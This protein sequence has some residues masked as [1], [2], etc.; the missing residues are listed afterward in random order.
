[1]TN[2]K[3][4]SIYLNDHLAATIAGCDLTRRAASSNK[5]TALGDFLERLAA[6]AEEDKQTLE[7]LMEEIGVTKNLLKDAAAWLSEKVGRLKL[8]GQL[9]GYSDLSRL[10]ELDGISA[11]LEAKACLW[12]SLRGISDL[13]PR[14]A[15]ANL[16]ELIRRT[17]RQREEL[18]RFR[19]EIATRALAEDAEADEVEVAAHPT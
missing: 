8:N 5:G 9:V 3:H 18:E 12:R 10:I 16:D 15:A 17:E 19:V 14:V 7:K 4:L 2:E 6:E 11:G 13:E 1:M